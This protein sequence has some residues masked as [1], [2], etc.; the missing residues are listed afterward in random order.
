MATAKVPNLVN[1]TVPSLAHAEPIIVTGNWALEKGFAER[2]KAT[3]V[4][5]AP[6]CHVES[7][8]TKLNKYLRTTALQLDPPPPDEAKP[9][10]PVKGAPPPSPEFQP[11]PAGQVFRYA[12]VQEVTTRLMEKFPDS[13]TPD[14]LGELSE[15]ELKAHQRRREQQAKQLAQRLEE[16]CVA[17]IGSQELRRSAAAA[18][19]SLLLLHLCCCC[20]CRLRPEF[21]CALEQVRTPR[22]DEI[23]IQPRAG[24]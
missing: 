2:R 15:E 17:W 12:R 20:C 19:A 3:R 21:G 18:A 9:H 14:Q 5:Q 4:L 24:G 8:R 1:A 11:G 23:R 7:R 10:S 22:D 16:R 6:G 13:L